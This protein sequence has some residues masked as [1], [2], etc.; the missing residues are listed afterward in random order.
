MTTVSIAGID[1][2]Q[3]DPC[4]LYAALYGV[5][6]KRLAGQEVEELTIQSPLTRETV[7]YSSIS[8]AA[9]EDHLASLKAACERK[10]GRRSRFAASIRY[11]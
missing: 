5:Y 1:I 8:L 7:K 11:S 9:F 3:D 6:L 10:R 2:D 4:A